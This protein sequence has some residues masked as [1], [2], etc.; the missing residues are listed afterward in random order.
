MMLDEAQVESTVAERVVSAGFA[1]RNGSDLADAGLAPER[2]L[3]GSLLRDAILRLNPPLARDK[4]AVEQVVRTLRNPP[5]PTFIENN[6]W[7]HRQTVDGVEVE[8]ADAKMKERRGTR[9]ALL[10]FDDPAKNDFLVVRQL[11]MPTTDGRHS[12][13]RTWFCSSTD[14]RSP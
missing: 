3:I 2:G 4:A 1:V 5:H 7:F 11:T 10:N 8:Y 12:R 14:C 6:R 9:A 13:G